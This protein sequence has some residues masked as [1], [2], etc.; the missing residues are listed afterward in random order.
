M[1]AQT[2]MFVEEPLKVEAYSAQATFDSMQMGETKYFGRQHLQLFRVF[3]GRL[4]RN[5]DRTSQCVIEYDG[6]T[7]GVTKVSPHFDRSNDDDPA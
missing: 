2:D 7:I 3:A 4:N 5:P 6:D 1:F